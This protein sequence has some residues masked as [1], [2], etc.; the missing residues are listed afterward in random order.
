V[1]NPAARIYHALLTPEPSSTKRNVGRAERREARSREAR[2]RRARVRK[3]LFT[4]GPDRLTGGRMGRR[5]L[6][7]DVV[8]R[9]VEL[10]VPAWPEAFDGLRIGHVSDFHLG[11]L[12][13]IGKAL[14]VV[15]LLEAQRVDFIAC[16]GDVVDLHH[17]EAPPLLEALAAIE[18]P[19]GCALVLGNHD[20]LH[21]P[22]ELTRMANAAGLMVL[23]N[24]AIQINHGGGRVVVAGID[25]AKS[26]AQCARLV[27][28]ACGD[29][30]DLLLAH[31][32][33]AF[34]RAAEL[35]VSLTLSGHTHG[36]QVAMKNRPAAN[37]AAPRRYT[38]GLYQRGDSHLYVTAGVGAWFPLRMNCPAEIAIITVRRPRDPD[39]G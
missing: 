12:L 6:A 21:C 15:E 25:W 9:E 4:I 8:V 10:T 24:D 7:Q 17:D 1:G 19:F 18:A 29:G 32:P 26:A 31:N 22:R 5:H 2:Y 11:E 14:E 39:E 30:A 27:D 20:E 3:F 36:G 28:L 13:P 23:R 37:L 35:D 34:S 16:T 33:R 38:A